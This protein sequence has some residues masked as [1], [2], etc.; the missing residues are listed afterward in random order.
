MIVQLPHS[1]ASIS[2]QTSK[3][4]LPFYYQAH[5]NA[6]PHTTLIP[7]SALLHVEII[8]CAHGNH[9]YL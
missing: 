3:T 1:F 9:H 8:K 7:D 4:E 2:K 5:Q 6:T